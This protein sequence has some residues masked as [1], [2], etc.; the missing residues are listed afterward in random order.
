[1]KH[2][3]FLD[4]TMGSYVIPIDEHNFVFSISYLSFILKI[5]CMYSFFGNFIY[6]YTFSN[7]LLK[8][9]CNVPSLSPE[10]IIAL[11]TL[12]NIQKLQAVWVM[13][14]H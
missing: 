4:N 7:Y 1:M 14:T 5:N 3:N 6:A 2:C 8:S 13:I 11:F 9:L 12:P 10:G